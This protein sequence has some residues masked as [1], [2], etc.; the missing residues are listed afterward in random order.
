MVGCVLPLAYC[1]CVCL[2]TSRNSVFTSGFLKPCCVC[3]CF[4]FV[5]VHMCMYIPVC[6]L[7]Y[8]FPCVYPTHTVEVHQRLCQESWKVSRFS[9]L[10]DSMT[11]TVSSCTTVYRVDDLMKECGMVFDGFDALFTQVC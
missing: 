11:Q 6:I 10:N 9:L 2:Q 1:M 3:M 4:C 8:N 7:M 5:C